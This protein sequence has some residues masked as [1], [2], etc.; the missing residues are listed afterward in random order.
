MLAWL[1]HTGLSVGYDMGIGCC[2]IPAGFAGPQSKDSSHAA[3][4]IAVESV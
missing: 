2:T 4:S 1:L 3:A